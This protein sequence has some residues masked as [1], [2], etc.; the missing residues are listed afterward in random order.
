M[1][2]AMPA[3]LRTIAL[4]QLSA[5]LS[6]L[7]QYTCTAAASAVYDEIGAAPNAGG[8]KLNLPGLCCEPIRTCGLM[9]RSRK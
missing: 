9:G 2:L 3:M 7:P 1:P 4:N 8:S 6:P 5:N